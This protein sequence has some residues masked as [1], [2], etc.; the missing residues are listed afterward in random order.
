M[1]RPR[2]AAVRTA[3]LMPRR[4]KQDA[5]RPL[6]PAVLLVEGAG[7]VAGSATGPP[8]VACGVT[9][10]RVLL[11]AL[12]IAPLTG[13]AGASCGDLPALRAERDQARAAYGRLIAA[14]P[15]PAEVTERAD[16]DVHALD[17]Q[18]FDVEQA[19]EGR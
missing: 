5:W 1:T 7:M 10:R 15:A 16:A 9:Y 6:Q 8:A 14:E 18:V 13:C 4:E 3:P 12:A 19:C 17:R 2:H 11:V